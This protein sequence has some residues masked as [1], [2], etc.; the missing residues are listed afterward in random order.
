ML[1][2]IKSKEKFCLTFWGIPLYTCGNPIKQTAFMPYYE[3]ERRL[4]FRGK[5][6]VK[7]RTFTC[8]I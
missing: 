3:A 6:G 1:L 4:Y 2:I 8:R 7:R 5:G